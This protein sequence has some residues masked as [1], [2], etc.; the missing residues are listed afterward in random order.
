MT[1][2][3]VEIYTLSITDKV[4]FYEGKKKE[5]KFYMDLNLSLEITLNFAWNVK[6]KEIILVV[7]AIRVD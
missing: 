6:I 4:Q 7:E 2:F 1:I 3:F 5:W